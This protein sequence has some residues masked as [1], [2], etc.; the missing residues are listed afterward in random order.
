MS[1]ARGMVTG[2]LGLTLL[3]AL[4]STR[5]ATGHV[6]GTIGALSKGLAR[7]LSPTAPLIPDLT[8]DAG[9]GTGTLSGG[10]HLPAKPSALAPGTN[11]GPSTGR[12][13]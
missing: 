12:P 1:A 3:E 7:W 4:L 5:E 10:M 6:T 9:L 11:A 2:L 8:G 13:V